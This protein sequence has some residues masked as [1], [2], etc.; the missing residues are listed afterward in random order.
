MDLGRGTKFVSIL[1]LL[2]PLQQM[3][4]SN[5]PNKKRALTPPPNKNSALASVPLLYC[6][7][8]FFG[9]AKKI[10]VVGE[11]NASGKGEEVMVRT[12]SQDGKKDGLMVTSSSS[13]SSS[14][15]RRDR[16]RGG[17]KFANAV[18]VFFHILV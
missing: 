16:Q 12:R 6:H 11:G 10:F 2:L 15:D 8:S 4:N 5:P 13:S 17:L 3:A 9:K 7:S 14:S 18:P 1:L